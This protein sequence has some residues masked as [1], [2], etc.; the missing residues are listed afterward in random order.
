MAVPGLRPIFRYPARLPSKSFGGLGV[1]LCFSDVLFR[2]APLAR[3]LLAL[4]YEP[5]C[6]LAVSNAAWEAFPDGTTT[7]RR[8]WAAFGQPGGA[9][10]VASSRRFHEQG[11]RGA[12]RWQ[13]EESMPSGGGSDEY[14]PV[15]SP[16][17][18]GGF[19]ELVRLFAATATEYAASLS[20]SGTP[21]AAKI[22]DERVAGAVVH[23]TQAPFELS[24]SVGGRVHGEYLN[25]LKFWAAFWRDDARLR[26]RHV[27]KPV[28]LI[29][30]AAVVARLAELGAFSR[31]SELLMTVVWEQ[32]EALR[33]LLSRKAAAD[34][35]SEFNHHVLP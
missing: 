10:E 31:Q 20:E 22:V 18:R 16:D 34:S 26:V 14:C 33:R 19:L 8:A 2:S 30:P 35:W 3:Q 17:E 6:R 13:L 24:I 12:A 23:W 9:F 32:F 7:R 21:A 1:Q 27:S 5:V 25:G 11:P 29:A 4:P 15:A 28:E